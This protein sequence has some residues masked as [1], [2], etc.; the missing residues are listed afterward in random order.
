MPNAQGSAVKRQKM[1]PICQL[2]DNW[3]SLGASFPT[4]VVA[5]SRC[6]MTPFNCSTLDFDPA[7]AVNAQFAP[8]PEDTSWCEQ[9]LDMLKAYVREHN[10]SCR[11]LAALLGCARSHAAR[12]MRGECYPSARMAKRFQDATGVRGALVL[13]LE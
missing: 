10:L 2:F 8:P 13:G 12:I 5:F 4:V 6:A 9:G 7:E 1:Q 3:L 11:A